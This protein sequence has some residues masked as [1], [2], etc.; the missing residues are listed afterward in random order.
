MNGNLFKE[1]WFNIEKI[2]TEKSKRRALNLKLNSLF[3][4]LVS[5]SARRDSEV[6]HHFSQFHSQLRKKIHQK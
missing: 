2:E 6:G 1:S 4:T 3:N 5:A